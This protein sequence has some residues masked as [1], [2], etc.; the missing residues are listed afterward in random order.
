MRGICHD[1][2]RF[3][4]VSGGTPQIIG[5]AAVAVVV[6]AEGDGGDG[7]GRRDTDPDP[8]VQDKAAKRYSLPDWEEENIQCLVFNKM[9]TITTIR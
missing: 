1:R 9:V 3:V 8:P 5:L 6:G 7:G 4:L 2:N